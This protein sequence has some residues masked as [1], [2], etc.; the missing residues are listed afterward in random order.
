MAEEGGETGLRSPRYPKRGSG[1][2]DAIMKATLLKRELPLYGMLIVPVVL[3]FVYS[4]IPMVG[5]VMAFQD[6]VPYRQGFVYSLFHSEFVGLD[7]FKSL[8]H[9]PGVTSVIYNTFFISIL[10]IVAKLI[11]PLIF[12]LLLNEIAKSWFRKLVMG[13]HHSTFFF[14]NAVQFPY[15][16]VLSDLWKEIG[17]NTIIFLAALTAVD[18]SMY[19]AAVIDGAGKWKQTLYLT[20]P[21]ITPMIILVGILSL[22]NVLN[23]GQDQI[24]NLYSPVVYSSG[25]IIDTFAFRQ[26]IQQGQFSI[27]TAVGLFKSLV[28]FTMI[29][30]AYLMANKLTNYKVF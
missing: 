6:F 18:P 27:A 9:T 17:Y 11:F 1:M 26:G 30:I 5:F 14:G 23:A 4:Y 7:V 20:L 21:S 2:E 28:S 16:V 3:V 12:A 13:I 25:D 29:S 15:A 22:G 8:L 10:K 24:L 19:E